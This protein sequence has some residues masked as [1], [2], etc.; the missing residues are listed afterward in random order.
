MKKTMVAIC[1]H[2][3][4]AEINAGGAMAKWV[5]EGGMVHIIMMG[6]NCSGY[7]I[8]DDR[9]ET[10]RFRLPP[11]E[12]AAI[13]RREQ[14][15]AAKL[16]GAKVHYQDYWQRHYWNGKA[17]VDA[18]FTA[19]PLYPYG[20]KPALCILIAC[21][22]E[23]CIRQLADLLVSLHP[24]VV[25]TQ[26]PLDIDPEHHAVSAMTWQAFQAAP[27]LK[28]VPLRYWTASTGS[29]DG[30][31]APDYD[32]FEDISDFYAMKVKLCEAHASQW[33]KNRQAVVARR[34]VQWG[35]TIGVRYA[36][37]FLAAAWGNGAN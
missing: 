7:I 24:S 8:P 20:M 36:E 1:A 23:P 18:G 11:P 32:H 10:K 28:G 14:D 4:D 12:T 33:T 5:A 22:E 13:R 15:A 17:V 3:D 31:A 34:A 16:I 30:T 37:P 2:A 25:L 27:A 29:P 9:D 26:T 6:N 21:N 35:K 19:D